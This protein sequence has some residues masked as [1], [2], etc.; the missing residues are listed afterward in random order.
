MRVVI[1]GVAGGF[2][3]PDGGEEW[4]KDNSNHDFSK[5]NWHSPSIATRTHPDFVRMV[6]KFSN[7]ILKVVEV[8]DGI[9]IEIHDLDD[10]LEW[11]AEKHRTWRA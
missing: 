6:E 7:Y 10:G 11:I 2:A 3:L 1:N 9:E 8:P 4:L 5:E